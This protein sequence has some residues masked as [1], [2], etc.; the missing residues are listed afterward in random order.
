MWV[1]DS[2][3][4]GCCGLRFFEATKSKKYFEGFWT[5]ISQSKFERE[6]F[7]TH[8]QPLFKIKR[9]ISRVK[10]I[11][12]PRQLSIT[13]LARTYI[14]QIKQVLKFV[15]EMVSKQDLRWNAQIDTV[16]R[17]RAAVRIGSTCHMRHAGY[18]WTEF[19]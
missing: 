6:Q 10:Q 1:C 8:A 4:F 18:V 7:K 11:L 14:L 3:G 16:I 13:K 9:T 2:V 12:L 15:C 17:Q 5:N 19:M